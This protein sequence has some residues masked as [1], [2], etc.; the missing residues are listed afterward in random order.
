MKIEIVGRMTWIGV[1]GFWSCLALGL[2]LLSQGGELDVAGG[3]ALLLLA[4]ACWVWARKG[5]ERARVP[6]VLVVVLSLVAAVM[7]LVGFWKWD[8]ERKE[9]ELT[10]MRALI[11]RKI[12]ARE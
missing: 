7:F 1:I 12:N 5:D 10:D 8:Q 6:G 4:G 11:D 9:R 2:W 3:V